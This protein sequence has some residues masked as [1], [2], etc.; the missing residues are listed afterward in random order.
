VAVD[1]AGRFT[2]DSIFRNQVDRTA[3]RAAVLGDYDSY[4]DDPVV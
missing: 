1:K 3:C 4:Y 2:F